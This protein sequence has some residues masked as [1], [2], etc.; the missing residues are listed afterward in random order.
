[1]PYPGLLHLELLWQA[2]ADPYLCRRHS[3]TV[4]AQSLWGVWIL[5]SGSWIL[6]KQS[7]FE[8]P[9]HLW[10]VWGLILNTISPL[11]PSWWGFSFAH[12]HRVSFFGGIQHSPV[13]GSAASCDF[14]VLT[15]E[16]E[17]MS[18]YS[19]ILIRTIRCD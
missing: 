9:E 10:R 8:P 5:V 14:G 1:M 3:D 17:C 15:G 19:S 18:F 6:L 16:D 2:T 7:L 4:L 11:L 13:D 12:G